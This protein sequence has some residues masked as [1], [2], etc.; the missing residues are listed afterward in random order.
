MLSVGVTG[1]SADG[2]QQLSMFSDTKGSE[3]AQKLDTAIDSIR[4]RFG[5]DAVQFGKGLG[6]KD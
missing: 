5:R 1:L 2:A 3:K 6:K 4:S